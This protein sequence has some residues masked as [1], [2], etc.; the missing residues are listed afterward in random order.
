MEEASRSSKLPKVTNF[1]HGERWQ[2]E[3]L[4]TSIL[5]KATADNTDTE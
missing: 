1:V 5:N 2:R 3:S 4:E